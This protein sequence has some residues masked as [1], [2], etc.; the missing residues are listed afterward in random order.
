MCGKRGSLAMICV[1]GKIDCFL[2]DMIIEGD[3]FIFYNLQVVSL[4]ILKDI[5]AHFLQS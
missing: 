4:L 2:Y 1:F 3:L 5:V